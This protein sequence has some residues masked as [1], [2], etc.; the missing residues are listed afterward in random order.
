FDLNVDDGTGPVT[1][2]IA[3]ALDDVG[4]SKGMLLN[5]RTTD[6]NQPQLMG[7]AG[8]GSIVSIYDNGVLIG[9]TVA[10]SYGNWTFTTP[11]LSNGEHSLIASADGITSAPFDLNVVGTCSSH[12]LV[13]PT[14]S[15]FDAALPGDDE[16]DAEQWANLHAS[17]QTPTASTPAF[18][19]LSYAEP[20]NLQAM[21]GLDDIVAA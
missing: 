7:Q 14:Q 2:Y 13:D 4:N 17:L 10:D 9:Q 8:A 18:A 11:A 21:I 16:P 15:L 20:A 5:G 6:D 12:A 1:P 19:E 3:S